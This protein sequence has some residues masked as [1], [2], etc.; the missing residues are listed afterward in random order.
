MIQAAGLKGFSVGK[1]SVSLKHANFIVT[2]KGVTS[3]DYHRLVCHVQ[4]KVYEQF[5][6]LLEPE[7]ELFGFEVNG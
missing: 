7:I 3:A 1:A 5:S 2:E 6:V 4:N